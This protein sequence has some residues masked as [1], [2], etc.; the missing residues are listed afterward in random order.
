MVGQNVVADD[1]ETIQY[2]NEGHNDTTGGQ[3]VFFDFHLEAA[4]VLTSSVLLVIAPT[5]M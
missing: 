1:A 4:M 2:N 5:K 3:V